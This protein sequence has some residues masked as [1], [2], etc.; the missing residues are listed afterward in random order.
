M[1]RKIG[2][3]FKI[4]SRL[5]Y[6]GDLNIIYDYVLII[7]CPSYSLIGLVSPRLYTIKMMFQKNNAKSMRFTPT[8]KQRLNRRRDMCYLF[9]LPKWWK[10]DQ[11]LVL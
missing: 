9:H 1:A 7:N 4:S 10:L 2:I 5:R 8:V 11:K 3:V 6:Y